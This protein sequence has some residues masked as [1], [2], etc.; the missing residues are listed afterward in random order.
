MHV[1]YATLLFWCRV[2]SALNE[3]T[4]AVAIANAR[5]VAG[6]IRDQN[7]LSVWSFSIKS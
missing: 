3:T 1:N 2:I 6:S 5:F 4:L 7:D